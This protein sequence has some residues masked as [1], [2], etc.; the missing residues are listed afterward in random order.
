MSRIRHHRPFPHR[1]P[2]QVAGAQSPGVQGSGACP[3]PA[4]ACEVLSAALQ[5]ANGELTA[6]PWLG[7][8]YEK[9]GAWACPES[10]SR[11]RLSSGRAP[12]RVAQHV[13]PKTPAG[14][15]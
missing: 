4:A 9:E 14:V 8:H 1:W 12:S 15:P 2:V 5:P 3:A 6:S 13:A 7:P 11:F 10:R